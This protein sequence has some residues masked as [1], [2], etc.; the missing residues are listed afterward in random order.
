M[1]AG[2]LWL[3]SVPHAQAVNEP[4]QTVI[5]PA[6][7]PPAPAPVVKEP[8][9]TIG[10]PT[11]PEKLPEELQSAYQ[12]GARNIVIRPGIYTIPPRNQSVFLLNGWKDVNIYAPGV[13]LIS[14]ETQG[15]SRLFELNNCDGVTVEGATLT[16]AAMSFYQGNITAIEQGD[17]GQKYVVWKPDAGYPVP[18]QGDSKLDCFF[19][20]PAT[21]LLKPGVGDFFGR[22]QTSRGDGTFQ[23]DVDGRQR[24]LNVGDKLVGRYGFIPFK[25]LLFQSRNCT[26]SNVTVSQGGFSP[27]REDG[28]GGG[29]NRILNCHWTPGPTTAGVTTQPLVSSWADGFH[30]TFANPGPDIE[31]CTFDGIILDDPF[32]IHGI[33][34]AVVASNGRQ[35]TVKNDDHFGDMLGEQ[36]GAAYGP[37]AKAR[38]YTQSGFVGLANVA[39]TQKNA[40]GTVTLTLD[41]DLKVPVGAKAINPQACGAGFKILNCQI[42]GTRSRGIVAKADDGVIAGNLIENCGMS[43]IKVGPEYAWDEGDYVRNVR[44]ENNKF[45]RNGEIGGATVFVNGEGAEGNRGVVIQNNLF[46]SNF[47]NDIEAN[48][49]QG[50]TVT[51]NTFAPLQ[52]RP[53]GAKVTVPLVLSNNR[54]VSVSINT[55]QSPQNYAS[56]LVQIGANVTGLKSDIRAGN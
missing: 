28:L 37:T 23:V 3:R 31:N 40:D 39:S 55:V 21:K 26:V 9:V 48:W 35:I 51:S 44:I 18:P 17:G 19:A 12:N 52:D 13:T 53:A 41:T 14:S 11:H 38:F 34:T 6:P 46:D 4:L 8:H 42:R 49:T 43:A 22:A 54:D 20:D 5:N 47:D 50:L 2:G 30:S 1:V 33:Y 32:A 7:P 29:G 10:D 16:Q 15:A 24:L 56:Q 45:L 27:I 25:V 36:F